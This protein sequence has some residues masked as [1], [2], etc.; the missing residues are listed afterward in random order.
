MEFKDA[1]Q[2]Y[3]DS[4]NKKNLNSLK[5][6]LPESGPMAGVM[7]DGTIL[8]SVEDYLD[9]HQEWFEDEAWSITHDVVFVEESSEMAYG[10]A[11]GDYFDKDEEGNPYSMSLITTC[12]MRKVDGQGVATHYQQ[13]ESNLDD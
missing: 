6:F 1:L 8:D 9:F 11:E 13:T 2:Q 4:I 5:K 10:V 12:I 7:C 3:F